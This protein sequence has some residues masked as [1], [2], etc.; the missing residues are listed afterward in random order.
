MLW[1]SVYSIMTSE[2]V[3][4]PLVRDYEYSFGQTKIQLVVSLKMRRLFEDHVQIVY[5]VLTQSLSL[6]KLVHC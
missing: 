6:H 4:R 5:Q 3:I 2:V 1:T